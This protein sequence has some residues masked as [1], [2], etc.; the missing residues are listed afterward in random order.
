MPFD[1]PKNELDDD[2]YAKYFINA[3]I[4]GNKKITVG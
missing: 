2:E 3:T 4:T 1:F